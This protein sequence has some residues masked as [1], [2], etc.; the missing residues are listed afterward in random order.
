M[1]ISIVL[2]VGYGESSLHLIKINSSISV[3]KGIGGIL[4]ILNASLTLNPLRSLQIGFINKGTL[5]IYL[6]WFLGDSSASI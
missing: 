4:Q 3:I 6:L 2:N 5:E 1:C